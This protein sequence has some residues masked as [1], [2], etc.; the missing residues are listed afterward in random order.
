MSTV[1]KPEPGEKQPQQIEEAELDKIS[2]GP[3]YIQIDNRTETKTNL[4]D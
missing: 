3:K 4:T 1:K 2:G